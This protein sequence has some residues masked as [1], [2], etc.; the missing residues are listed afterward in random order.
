MWR[1]TW[2]RFRRSKL[3]VAALL[4]VAAVS[5]VAA[6]APL[7][8]ADQA[9][10]SAAEN[11]PAVNTGTWSDSDDGLT[12]SADHGSVVQH[13]NGSADSMQEM[14]VKVWPKHAMG[15]SSHSR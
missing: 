4:Y 8:A 6:A 12:L 2:R 9:A 10:V 14:F 1:E 15:I 5:I 13:A 7:V 3:A 11:M